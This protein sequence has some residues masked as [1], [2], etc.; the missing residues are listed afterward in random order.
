MS[1]RRWQRVAMGSG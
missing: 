1:T